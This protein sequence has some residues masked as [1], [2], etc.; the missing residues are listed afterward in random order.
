MLRNLLMVGKLLSVIRGDG[1]NKV[2]I[3]LGIREYLQLICLPVANRYQGPFVVPAYHRIDFQVT[4]LDFS[5][6]TVGLS[7]ICLQL[8][9]MPLLSFKARRSNSVSPWAPNVVKRPLFLIC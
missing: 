1:F 7:G 4:I 3:C 5:S 8:D 6:N 2:P 9:M